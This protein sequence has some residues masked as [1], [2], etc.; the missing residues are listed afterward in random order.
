[1]ICKNDKRPRA[2]KQTYE[3]ALAVCGETGIRVNFDDFSCFSNKTFKGHY[4]T[5][6]NGMKRYNGTH[7][8]DGTRIITISNKKFP[9]K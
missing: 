1:M 7:F 8:T 9:I 3:Q 2:Y 5:F 6:W 4:T